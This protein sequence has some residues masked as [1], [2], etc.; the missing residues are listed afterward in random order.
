MNL[1]LAEAAHTEG[2]PFWEEVWSIVSDPA[3]I[4]AELSWQLVFDGLFVAFL[5]GVIVKRV[6]IPRL[7]KQIHAELDEEHGIEHHDDHIH[8]TGVEHH[9]DDKH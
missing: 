6:I 9:D 7:R 4:I 1:F 2:L 5:Y 3:H 8:I